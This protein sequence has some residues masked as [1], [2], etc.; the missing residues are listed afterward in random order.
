MQGRHLYH[1]L[2]TYQFFFGLE[3]FPDYFRKFRAAL[4]NRTELARRGV[5]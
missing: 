4:V 1:L 2:P 5:T 3:Q